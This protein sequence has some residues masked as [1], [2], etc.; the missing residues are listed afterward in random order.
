MMR[1]DVSPDY[2]NVK[3]KYAE[4]YLRNQEL[5]RMIRLAYAGLDIRGQPVEPGRPR[6]RICNCRCTYCVEKEYYGRKTEIHET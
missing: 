2:N 1:S 5:R 6:C 3:K 4:R